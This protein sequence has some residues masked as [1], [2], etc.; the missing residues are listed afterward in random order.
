MNDYPRQ[1]EIT[2]LANVPRATV[3]VPGSKSI[4][5]RA[6]VLAALTA[7][8]QHAIILNGVLQ[9]DDTEIMIACLRRLGCSFAVDWP[10]ACVRVVHG[11]AE[12]DW[13]MPWTRNSSCLEAFR[14]EGASPKCSSSCRT[15]TGPTCSIILSATNASRESMRVE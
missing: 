11:S 8:K 7:N 14:M 15:R 12:P 9:S 2:P 10:G 6:F 4:T 1:L 5:N 3:H 13:P